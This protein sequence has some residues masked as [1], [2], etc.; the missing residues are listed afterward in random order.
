MTPEQIM[1]LVPTPFMGLVWF[2]AV[3][4]SCQKSDVAYINIYINININIYIYI[5]RV[6]IIHFFIMVQLV[7]HRIFETKLIN[8]QIVLFYMF[9]LIFLPNAHHLCMWKLSKGLLMCE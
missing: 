1:I 6:D 2:V 5:Y 4:R 7:Y 8:I 9:E 3:E